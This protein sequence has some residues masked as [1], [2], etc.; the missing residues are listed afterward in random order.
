MQTHRFAAFALCAF[1]LAISDAS[2]AK[3]KPLKAT[4]ENFVSLQLLRTGGIAG[5][6]ED[7]SIQNHTLSK[8]PRPRF[9]SGGGSGPAYMFYNGEAQ[10]A[11]L[12]QNQ[13]RELMKRLGKADLP[14][15][16]GD[17]K[18]PRLADGI[19]ETVTLT[20]SDS[21]NSDCRFV[22]SNYGDKAPAPL[23]EFLGYLHTLVRSKGF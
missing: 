14:T 23:R 22:V 21:Q 8:L 5:I 10:V 16:V 2:Y 15:V 3:P 20:L 4:S 7:Y 18:D 11:P 6:R 1:L 17:Y 12:S 13:W 19:G 9:E